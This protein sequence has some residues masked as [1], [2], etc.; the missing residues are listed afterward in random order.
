MSD[1][2]KLQSKRGNI[3]LLQVVQQ[4]KNTLVKFNYFKTSV[5]FLTTCTQYLFSNQHHNQHH[6]QQS[7]RCIDSKLHTLSTMIKPLSNHPNEIDL[8]VKHKQMFFRAHEFWSGN[9]NDYSQM[10]FQMTSQPKPYSIKSHLTVIDAVFVYISKTEWLWSYVL[11]SP[12][13]STF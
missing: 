11:V 10:G 6:G 2:Q 1:K 7:N 8:P 9:I 13:S 12:P 3:S 4:T 5:Q